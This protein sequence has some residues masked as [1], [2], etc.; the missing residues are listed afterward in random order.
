MGTRRYG[1]MYP[2]HLLHRRPCAA[3]NDCLNNDQKQ[4]NQ[5]S[6]S[7]RAGPWSS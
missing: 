3:S 4:A 7:M 6:M 1:G 5:H 2:L